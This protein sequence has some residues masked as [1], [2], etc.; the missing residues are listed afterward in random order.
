MTMI[1][2]DKSEF[3]RLC[4]GE[5]RVPIYAEML[6]DL[7]TPVSVYWKLANHSKNSFLLESV[8]GG[9]RLS[10][11]SFIGAD[12][13][14]TIKTKGRTVF[15][16][17]KAQEMNA[18]ETPLDV[19]RKHI[20]AQP[21]T[22][23]E[24]LPR[25]TGGAVGTLSYDLVRFFEKIPTDTDDDLECPD[26]SML[27]CDRMIA[28]D[29][30]KNRILVIAHASN[31]QEY[32]EA[33]HTILETI[34]H[35][36]RP[37]PSLPTAEKSNPN[38]Q[39]NMSRDAFESAVRKA[40]QYIEEGDVVQVVISQRFSTE[41][42]AHPLMIYR[43]LRSL[44]PSPYM[45]LLRFGDMDI[46]GASPEV[47]VTYE[48]GRVRVR[49]IAGTRHRGKTEEEDQKIEQ[50]LINDEKERAEHLM[51]VDLGRNDVGRI[52]KPGTVKMN[53]FMVVERYSHV[54][55]IVSDVTGI[56]RDDLDSFDVFK[57][58]FPAGTVSGAP[59]V[60]A[61]EIIEELEPTRR[62]TYAGAVGYFGFN[63]DMDMAIAIRTI[64]L[65]NGRAHIQAGAGIVFD[66]MPENEWQE[67]HNK[68]K[69]VIDAV[70]ITETGQIL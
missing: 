20:G 27:L 7:Q 12:A 44:N 51:L 30:A 57:A 19:I 62:G 65:K 1:R 38:F 13:K 35:L 28:F 50:E 56:V 22:R 25:F 16:N 39:S 24:G 8:T 42:N 64:L 67:C 47:L 32:D 61:M 59:K 68:A 70:T 26:V 4:T 45:Y 48:E 66:S 10:R 63:G 46:I 43:A 34:E 6:A 11:Y 49:P 18:H 58:C 14:V 23:I 2:P 21:Y 36:K 40:I 54:M 3:K 69:A 15:V 33:C 55:H 53:E 60:R 29:H 41:A 17:N 9:E 52:A 5:N 37:L 31:E